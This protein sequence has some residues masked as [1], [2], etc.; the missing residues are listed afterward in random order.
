MA[1]KPATPKAATPKDETI[2][3]LKITLDRLKPAVWRRIQ[4][5]D[6]TLEDLHYIIQYCMPWGQS[7]L[8]EF[9]ISRDE[10][11]GAGAD[12]DRGG[13]FD[14]DD[15]SKPASKVKL[16]ALEARKIKKFK[17]NYDFGDDWNHTIT[18][19]KSAARDP[20]AKYPR[21]V[22]GELACPPDDCGGAGGYEHLLEVLADPKNPEH[23]DMME[24]VGSPID[25][26]AF[27]IDAINKSLQQLKV[28]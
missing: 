9:T 5:P 11:Y 6:C 21:C 3:V 26:E 25:P 10:R 18:F 27:D 8:W 1:K 13:S 12:E 2:F 24:W 28:K 4:V 7:H 17:Y 23:A 16:S 19:L 22:A 15:D 20:A 14:D